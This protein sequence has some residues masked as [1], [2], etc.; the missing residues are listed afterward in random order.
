MGLTDSNVD[1]VS[2]N[3]PNRSPAKMRWMPIA[4]TAD[5]PEM[6]RINRQRTK[7]AAVRLTKECF[8]QLVSKL[9]PGIDL[10]STSL[11]LL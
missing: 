8:V 6:K 4:A 10:L 11:S 3:L 5:F 7:I 1:I 2:V 9:L